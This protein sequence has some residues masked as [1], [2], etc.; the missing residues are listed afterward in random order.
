M[1]A[2][3]LPTVRGEPGIITIPVL[4]AAAAVHLEVRAV[5]Y[6]RR[7]CT[8]CNGSGK[9]T[10]GVFEGCC[11]DCA[12]SGEIEYWIED[13]SP[14]ARDAGPSDVRGPWIDSGDRYRAMGFTGPTHI[15]WQALRRE[16]DHP[17]LSADRGST[18][19]HP[20]RVARTWSKAD[21]PAVPYDGY[22]DTPANIRILEGRAR[23]LQGLEALRSNPLSSVLVIAAVAR[24][25]PRDE[26]VDW[27]IFGEACWGILAARALDVGSAPRFGAVIFPVHPSPSGQPPFQSRVWAGQLV[28]EARQY[29]RLPDTPTR[30]KGTIVGV[31]LTPTGRLEPVHSGQF[32]GPAGGTHLGGIPRG[33]GSGFTAHTLTH[34]EGHTAAIMWQRGLHR[35]ILF[36]EKAPCGGCDNPHATPNI[37]AMLPKGSQLVIISVTGEIN[38][39]RADE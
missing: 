37:S 35:A 30:S 25:A 31:L 28:K 6:V 1:G 14:A 13:D 8:T 38:Y 22:V 24:N 2:L 19:I 12:E 34:V 10:W 5:P 4:A 20:D 18:R 15:D 39:F 36:L 7:P 33:P 21:S 27:A 11:E 9:R 26:Q 29:F 16:S 3:A 23:E 32:G 17:H